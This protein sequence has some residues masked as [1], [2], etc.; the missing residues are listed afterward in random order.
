MPVDGRIAR[1]LFHP[2][3]LF[4]KMGDLPDG[5]STVAATHCRRPTLM[6]QELIMKHRHRG[7]VCRCY[8]FGSILAGRI[9]TAAPS[10]IPDSIVVVRIDFH[11]A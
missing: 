11:A 6:G 4:P 8:A 1:D 3:T 7:I 2:A 9:M 5:T 10:K